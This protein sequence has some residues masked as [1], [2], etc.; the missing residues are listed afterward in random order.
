M[1]HLVIVL[2]TVFIMS[3]GKAIYAA[4]ELMYSH[5]GPFKSFYLG[6]DL[7]GFVK[8]VPCD[9]CKEMTFKITPNVKAMLDDEIVP[10]KNFVMSKHKPSVLKFSKKT[11]QLVK[12]VWYSRDK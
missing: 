12:I 5:E 8:P 9:G 10:L 2:M 1:K 7:E 11:H 4:E 3:A 6:K